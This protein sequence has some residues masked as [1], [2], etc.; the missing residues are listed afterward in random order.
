MLRKK[1][2]VNTVADEKAESKKIEDAKK[3]E[4]AKKSAS[5]KKAEAAKKSAV[6]KK[7]AS[8]PPSRTT[9]R[10]KP[11]TPPANQREIEENSGPSDKED[12]LISN[13]DQ[14]DP[15]DE[16][17]VHTGTSMAQ[18]SAHTQIASYNPDQVQGG[19]LAVAAQAGFSGLEIGFGSF[20]IM[21]LDG[22]SFMIDGETL[23]EKEVP[24]IVTQTREKFI[25]KELCDGDT[26]EFIYSY[27]N[28]TDTSGVPVESFRSRLAGQGLE[29][30][31]KTYLEAVAEI[32]DG[33]FDGEFVLLSIPPSS[34]KR[35]SGYVVKVQHKYGVNPDKVV[36]MVSVGKKI[37]KGKN[38]W[39][40]WKFSCLGLLEDVLED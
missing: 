34:L 7:A 33:Q 16:T 2:T 21:K 23:D 3:A 20:D 18:P 14:S 31:T 25:I 37:T 40:P 35:F 39:C 15:D 11:P 38:S 12:N 27:D 13:V 28:V 8:K 24:M 19:A 6:K 4:A 10:K 29:V 30:E 22:E 36:T 17:E 1:S 26:D 9:S 5:D 32:K